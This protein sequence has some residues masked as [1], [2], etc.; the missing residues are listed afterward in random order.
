MEKRNIR[1]PSPP[2]VAASAP[3]VVAATLLSVVWMARLSYGP[4][5]TKTFEPRYTSVSAVKSI[6]TCP[7]KWWWEKVQKKSTPQTKAQKTGDE[8]HAEWEA[9]L[10]SGAPL[11]PMAFAGKSHQPTGELLSEVSIATVV[12]GA[13]V[14]SVTADDVP[15]VGYIDIL[16]RPG[17][18]DIKSTS[19]PKWA[20]TPHELVTDPQMV[21]YAKYHWHHY[22][23]SDEI[24]IA[25]W[26]FKTRPPWKSWMVNVPITKAQA[27]EAWAPITEAVKL[28]R[29]VAKVPLERVADVPANTKSCGAYGGCPHLGYCA[30]GASSKALAL[31]GSAPKLPDTPNPTPNPTSDKGHSRMP[32]P[33]GRLSP[34]ALAA[35]SALVKKERDINADAL[36]AAHLMSAIGKGGLGL[37]PLCGIVAQLY[38]LGKGIS[39][40]ALTVAGTGKIA[41][42]DPL[43][44]LD[45]LIELAHE[46]GVP[47]S[48][49]NW[50]PTAESAK[51]ALSKVKG[52]PA[53]EPTPEPAPQPTPEP[54][55]QP[56]PEPAPQPIPAE[57]APAA[58]P[59]ELKLV[60]ATAVETPAVEEEPTVLPPDAPKRGR[61]RPPGTSRIK[62][63]ETPHPAVANAGANL[64]PTPAPASPPPPAPVAPSPVPVAP[65]PAW[66]LYINCAPL[67]GTAESL[68]PY[69]LKITTAANQTAKVPDVR[70][71]DKDSPLAFG[72][73]RGALCALVVSMP[74]APGAYYLDTM[75]NEIA[76][77][78]AHALIEVIATA[79]GMVVKGIR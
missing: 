17:V 43:E 79:G 70:L 58:A 48:V 77:V 41:V 21:G 67:L 31:F 50:V 19:D 44:T 40:P 26:Y 32:T 47:E 66:A 33:F 9:H 12:D 36:R 15:F 71:A 16:H 46:A 75:G 54:A 22:N 34:E 53:P 2:R 68:Y 55:P 4:S 51:T 30:T 28:L 57:P 35:K 49:I 74:P 3:D 61:G 14:S 42:I 10:Q 78:V 27:D 1:H 29:A 5:L 6:Q 72:G 62:P 60:P 11:S 20:K 56:T 52:G 23:H 65:A 18:I 37:P 73:W 59:P 76:E 69:V 38:Q 25:H 24:T 45:H 64:T 39:K 7:L 63:G 8:L 13:V